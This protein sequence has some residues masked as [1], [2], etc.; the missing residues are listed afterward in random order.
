MK[1][2]DK[3]IFLQRTTFS[4]SSLIVTF[5][6]QK[7]GL[8]KFVFRGGKKK[9][10]NIFAMSLSELCYYGRRDSELLNLTSVESVRPQTFQFDPVKGAIAFFMAETLRKCVTLGQADE[11]FFDFI[12]QWVVHL[13]ERENVTL[14]PLEFLIGCS[15]ILGFKPLCDDPAAAVFNLDAG[16]FQISSSPIERTYRGDAVVLIKELIERKNSELTQKSDRE[17]ALEIML[18]YFRIHVPRF[19][20]L[21]SYEIVREVLRA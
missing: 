10:H 2:T 7:N 16:V 9:A 20:K 17:E 8:Q 14:F 4:D 5:F 15:E 6:T 18:Q 21:E 19:D 13:E 12:E 11:E 1:S 3:G